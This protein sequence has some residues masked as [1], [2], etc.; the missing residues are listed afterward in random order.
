MF[1][2]MEF[3]IEHIDADGPSFIINGHVFDYNKFRQSF[4]LAFCCTVYE[5]QGADIKQHYNIY[6]VSHIDKKQL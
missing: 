5:Y 4:I 6:D 2:M 1:K 3:E